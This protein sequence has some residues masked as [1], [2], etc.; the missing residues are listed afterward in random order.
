MEYT[1]QLTDLR[2][3]RLREFKALVVYANIDSIED[4]QAQAVLDYVAE[5]GGYVPLHCASYCFRNSRGLVALAG[6]QFLR[7]GTGVFRATRAEAD[8]PILN[9]FEGFESWDETYVH[10]QHNAQDRIVLEYRVEGDQR[11]PWTWVRTHGRGRVFYTAWGHDARTWGHPGFHNLIERG[12]RW[13]AR[14]DLAVVPPYRSD[15]GPF[16]LEMNPLDPKRKPFEFVDVGARIPNYT[17]GDRWG[18]QGE[19][20]RRMQKPMPPEES[21]RHAVVPVGFHVELFASEPDIGGKPIA[22]AWDERGRLWV[23]E[24]IDYPNELKPNGKGRDRVRICEDTDADGKADRFTVFA[25]NLSIPTA[26]AFHRGGAIVQA[27]TETLYL[28]DTN[29][30]DRA[31]TSRVLFSGWGMGDTHGGVSNFQYGL[32][33]WI[34]AMQ[35][36]NESAPTVHG[37]AGDAFRNGF[38]RFR[39]DGS[40]V[41]F[42]RSTNNNT[43]GLGISEEGIVFGSTA[44]RNPSV[45]M[46]IPNR[47]YES[48]RGWTK[49][50]MLGTI[51]DTFRFRPITGN[52]RQVD[53]FGGYTA[54]AGHAIYTARTYPREFWNRTAFV[55]GPTGHLTG[56]FVL[57]GSGADYRSTS[58]FNLFA[59][60]DEWSAPIMAEV[61]PDGHVWIGDWYN[62]IIQHNPTPIGFETGKGNA[63]ESEL[64]D[65]KHGRI[66]RVVYDAA[67]ASA[68][69][70]LAGADPDRLV[71]ALRH[72]TM[73]WRKH[74]QRLIVERGDASIAP[75]LI[76]RIADRSTDPIGLN[77]GAIHALGS[78]RGLGLLD[79]AHAEANAAVFAA[80]THPSAGVRRNAIQVLPPI[81]ESADRL[82]AARLL[83]DPDSQVRLAALLAL[84]D[85]PRTESAGRGLVS[86][87]R[88][89]AFAADPWISDAATIAAAKHSDMFMSS[90][91]GVGESAPAWVERVR[92]VAE[93]AA[94]GD[95]EPAVL[96]GLADAPPVLIEAGVAGVANGWP[97]GK[98]VRMTAELD[99]GLEKLLGRIPAGGR[100]GLVRL[101]T[102]WG[103]ER[104]RAHIAQIQSELLARVADG[105]SSE[106]ER[107]TAAEEYVAIVGEDAN[108]L[109]A[110]VELVQP[111][112]P[113]A[114]GIGR[115]RALVRS[116]AKEIGTVMVEK[117]PSLTPEL[118]AA[119]VAM[120][121]SRPD[122]TSALFD[123]VES[124][125]FQL[126]DLSLDQKQ[127]LRAH[128]NGDLR[129]RAAAMLE[130][131]GALPS[132]DRAAVLAEW[133]SVAQESGDAKAGKTVFQK[134]CAKCHSHNGE[135]TRVGPDLTGMSVHPKQELLTNVL[136]PNRSVEGNYRVYTIT[137]TDGIVLTG[138]L[139]SES[140]TALELFDAE[141]VRKTV[142]REDVEQTIASSKSLMPE[143]FEK[144]MSRAEVAD[145]LEFL[146]ARGKYVPLDLRRAATITSA[147]GMFISRE[148]EVER[149]IFPSWEPTR[150]QDVPFQ[151]I[152]PKEG[153]VP[154]AILLHGPSGAVSR[155][156][157]ERVELACNMPV[158]AIHML[159]G[160][161]GWGFPFGERGTVSMIVRLRYAD[162][163]TEDHELI[164]GE[165][166]AD[167]I[168]R[169][170]VP[171]SEFAFALRNQQV[172]YLSVNPRRREVIER[173]ELVKGPD[174]TSPI[175][176]AVTL[177]SSP[178]GE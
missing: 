84:A 21:L 20:Q 167:Y 148:S 116:D 45:Y 153:T 145:L 92:V 73:L 29:G 30:D 99:A 22:M 135:G 47:Y 70:S 150:F 174:A 82:I 7:H 130:R 85:L 160:V 156:M 89:P 151:L 74:A 62:F 90:L 13:V 36:Y 83:E 107:R 15:P 104:M 152:D 140:K 9:G 33:N 165:H 34:W 97:D 53:Q 177:E 93:H 39:P 125:A 115:L 61:G 79:G 114:V 136:D 67:P 142:L 95:F 168:R 25:E 178:S 173:I 5:G 175:V 133:L 132:A 63:Y 163:Q 27:G 98:P 139:A 57:S 128:P 119:A 60:E 3:D 172:R 159:S 154:N 103:S 54:G 23:A 102:R 122:W 96:L 69:M 43:W 76:E 65:K 146:A 19:S 166:F 169:V 56:T 52:V 31:D 161:S 138:L 46:P 51:A 94:R 16:V 1:D 123:G 141:G 2:P 131:G 8:H 50:L 124:G 11:E 108:A 120:L 10:H 105:G 12:I 129:R 78:L 28:K 117:A 176:M 81:G 100:G 49:A 170:D 77:V 37:K 26:I 44:N 86:A 80:L 40:Q 155:A 158:K 91:S 68:P 71:D 32:D 171:K 126:A 147:R 58:P 118:R 121:L 72:P 101:A 162:G 143:G 41:E 17:R 18:E 110:L 149:M 4:S 59:S 87:I 48:V 14:D 164:N 134:H 64:R 113:P 144:Q 111:R 42:I 6:A 109:R 35:G 137:T 66:Y 55:N 24:S 88:D 106:S 127:A 75:E 112:M 38:F 157:P